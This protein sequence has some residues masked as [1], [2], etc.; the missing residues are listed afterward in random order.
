[1]LMLENQIIINAHKILH[2]VCTEAL[3]C[4]SICLEE[5]KLKLHNFPT[6]FH[7]SHEQNL[8]V[9]AEREFNEFIFLLLLKIE[10]RE[11]NQSN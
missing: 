9:I 3:L 11:I 6:I 10:M 8:R 1:M 4:S 5:K 7:F 2:N